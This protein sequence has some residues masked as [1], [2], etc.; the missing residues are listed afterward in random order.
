MA[1]PLEELLAKKKHDV[2]NEAK[3]WEEKKEEWIARIDRLYQDI[4]DW[5][6]P[7]VEKEY[8][9]VEYVDIPLSEELLGRYIVKKMMIIFFNEEKI[10]IEPWGLN[11]TGANGR[12]DIKLGLRNI[13]IIGNDDASWMFAERLGRGQ[14]HTWD[15]NHDSFEE[16]LKNFIEA[17]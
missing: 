2:N 1:D 16:I 8:L 15:F 7:L 4:E 9:H 14:P 10:E 12:V 13:M 17:F 5:L 6:S 11:I 3:Q